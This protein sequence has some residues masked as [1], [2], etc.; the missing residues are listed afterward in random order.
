MSPLQTVHKCISSKWHVVMDLCFQYAASISSS[1]LKDHYLDYVWNRLVARIYY[2]ERNC[3][4][5]I[6]ERQNEYTRNSQSI[7]NTTNILAFGGTVF[8]ILIL[9]ASSVW[10]HL[11]CQIKEL[12]GKLGLQSS[13]EKDCPPFT[14]TVCLG[15]LIVTQEILSE[16]PNDRLLELHA[17]FL[18][19]LHLST[20][21]KRKF[22]LSLGKL[23][24]VTACIWLGRIFMLCLSNL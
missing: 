19:W 7:Q 12:F 14:W 20:F 3:S 24:F 10:V 2:K 9:G 8:C 1:I 21:T 22:Q 15:R 6:E 13:P 17:E 4:L 5:H 23:F 18:Q 11:P 16:V